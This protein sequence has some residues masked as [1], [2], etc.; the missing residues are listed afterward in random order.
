MLSHIR[1]VVGRRFDLSTVLLLMQ[2]FNLEMGMLGEMY[3][4]PLT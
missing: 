4:C 1:N 2:V 3:K